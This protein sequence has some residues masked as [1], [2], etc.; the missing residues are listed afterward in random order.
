VTTKKEPRVSFASYFGVSKAKLDKAGFFNISLIS[1]L[2]LFIDPFHLFYSDK[3]EYEALHDEI[4]KYLSFLRDY[5]INLNGSE[6]KKSD[7]DLYFCFPEVKQNWLGYAYVGNSGRGLGKKFATALNENFF[8]LFRTGT[9][10]HLEKLT[11]VADRVGKDSISDFTTNLI[12]AHLAS[13]TEEFAKKY[14]NSSKL[15]KFTIKKA[16]FDYKRKAWKHKTFTLPKLDNDYVILTPKDLLTKE[17]TW[18]NKEDFVHNFSEI[19]YAMSN[20][21][22]QAQLINYFNEKLVEFSEKKEDKRTGKTKLVKTAKTKRLAAQAT[23]AQFPETIDVYIAKKEDSG[24]Q[25]KKI[26]NDYVQETE[27]FK[28]NQY[29]HFINNTEGHRGAP[30]TYDDAKSRALYFKECVETDLYIDFYDKD[31]VPASEEW[32]QRQFLY[33]WGGTMNDVYR[34]PR[35]GRGR[36]DYVVSN[37]ARD[38]CIVEFK[39]AGS[40]SLEENLKNQLEAYKKLNKADHGLWIIIVFTNDEYQKLQL[41]IEKLNL[42]IEDIVIVDA[43][44][45]NK[46]SPSKMK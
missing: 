40:S 22:L 4:I 1:D 19:P 28:E 34:E 25:A 33:V 43:R 3:K 11:L 9:P 21:A 32:I 5:S 35:K 31:G 14:I 15:G 6:L 10:G 37:G 29:T 44:K 7:I 26:S 13:L 24:H 17:E 16:E 12:H 2:P 46:V 38:K 20:S 41:L 42:N 30:T 45:E 39:L 18:I 23:I 36:A 27:D 8:N